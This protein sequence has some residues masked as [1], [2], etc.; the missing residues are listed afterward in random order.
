MPIHR[1]RPVRAVLSAMVVI[2]IAISPLGCGY[3]IRPPYDRKFKTVYVPIFKSQRFRRDLN[4]QMTEML[5]KE[6]QDRTPYTVVG[7]PEDADTRLEGIIT[8]DDKN[9]VVESPNN[10]PRHELASLIATVTFIDNRTGASTTKVTPPALVAETSPFYPEIGE[11]VSLGF[12]KAMK[13]MVKDIVGMMEAPWGEEYRE[14]IDLP[15]DDPADA[16]PVRGRRR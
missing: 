13:K 2:V 7:S 11:T 6:I 15:P 3:S 9:I 10:L 14:D 4:L 5:Q 16:A 12:Q 1:S 8:Y